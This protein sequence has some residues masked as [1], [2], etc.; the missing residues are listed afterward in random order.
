MAQATDMNAATP[1]PDEQTFS[2]QMEGFA[3]AAVYMLCFGWFHLGSDNALISANLLA[4][5]LVGLI[6]VPL[7]AAL[8]MFLL[9]R[10][11]INVLGKQSSVAAFLPFARFALYALQGVLVWVATREAYMLVL[12]GALFAG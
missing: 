7:V 6:V 10:V 9:R 8:P 12:N 11:L 1:M 3:S 5:F 4:V 2:M